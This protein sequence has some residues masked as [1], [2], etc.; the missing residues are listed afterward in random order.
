MNEFYRHLPKREEGWKVELNLSPL[1]HFLSLPFFY[2]HALLSS[3]VNMSIFL[4]CSCFPLLLSVLT[5]LPPNLCIHPNPYPPTVSYSPF[6]YH[7]YSFPIALPL[8]PLFWYPSWYYSV[9][10]LPCCCFPSPFTCPSTITPPF[11]YASPFLFFQSLS[12]SRLL[13][14]FSLSHL[15]IFFSHLYFIFF[16]FNLCF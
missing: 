6:S 9:S 10:Q 3:V 14:Y 15:L 5:C 8:H 11:P 1:C 16:C 13:S 4:S 2:A 7:L 12:H